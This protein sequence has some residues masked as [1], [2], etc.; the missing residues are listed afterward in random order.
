MLPLGIDIG[1]TRVRVAAISVH[2]RR[3][4]I[5]NVVVRDVPAGASSSGTIPAP[6]VVAEI[7]RDALGEIEGADGRCV[8]TLS[9]DVA[10]I[11]TISLPRMS[12]F[13]RGKAARFEAARFIDYPLEESSV[14]LVPRERRSE[15][16]L[17]IA[18]T[19]ALRSRVRALRAAGLRPVAVDHEAC[20]WRRAVP[21]CDCVVDVGKSRSTIV[22]F[23][24]PLADVRTFSLG[25][26]AVTGSI[27]RSLGIGR[28][29]AEQRKRHLGEA[30][31]A[32][33]DI[34]PVVEQ[35]ADA[36]LELRSAGHVVRRVALAG[37]GA[38]VDG[39]AT[40]LERATGVPTAMASFPAGT[41]SPY[42][43][44]VLRAGAADW[45]FAYGIALWSCA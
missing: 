29:A 14:R 5:R 17:G 44:D 19:E 13:E 42:P 43:A 40:A 11:K 32:S 21:D 27:A 10:T 23:A 41:V 6:D 3:P 15:Y 1:T 26:E 34:A 35:I 28:D 24:D 18:R 31:V 4:R 39:L 38:R 20:A 22:V 9:N 33:G 16:L 2:Q 30:G 36:V 37:N 12:S 25:G 7:L 45:L 8:A